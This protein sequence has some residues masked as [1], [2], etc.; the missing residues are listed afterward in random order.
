MK[1]TALGLAAMLAFSSLASADNPLKQIRKQMCF[2]SYPIVTYDATGQHN[3]TV[4][5]VISNPELYKTYKLVTFNKTKLDSSSFIFDF[6]GVSRQYGKVVPAS[7]SASYDNGAWSLH[8][9][10]SAKTGSRNSTENQSIVTSLAVWDMYSNIT[11][12]GTGGG[13]VKFDS[14]PPNS[15]NNFYE[16]SVVKTIDCKDFNRN[17]PMQ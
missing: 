8:V 6:T 12:P 1:R 3:W 16:V 17:T 4:N 7:G 11:Q 2:E 15:D 5:E 13:F 9:A 14:V 10:A